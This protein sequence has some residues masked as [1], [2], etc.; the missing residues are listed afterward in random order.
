M[1]V[2]ERNIVLLPL[3]SVIPLLLTVGVSCVTMH[4]LTLAYLSVRA[5]IQSITT[6]SCSF[7]SLIVLHAEAASF[8]N[9]LLKS[10]LAPI[11]V[12]ELI[13]VTIDAEPLT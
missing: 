8:D 1:D 10:S 7:T 13:T 3:V 5:C 11:S 4:H 6:K 9:T 12:S 2:V